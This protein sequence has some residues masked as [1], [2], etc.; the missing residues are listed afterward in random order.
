MGAPSCCG[1]CAGC[2][3]CSPPKKMHA[4]LVGM[5]ND[6]CTSCDSL[7]DED[8]VIVSSLMTSSCAWL[9]TG[10]PVG[11]DCSRLTEAAWSVGN[12]RITFTIQLDYCL[13]LM[14]WHDFPAPPDCWGS[15]EAPLVLEFQQAYWCGNPTKRLCAKSASLV[16]VWGTDQ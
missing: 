9:W 5:S 8:A 1:D 2:Q 16:K 14:F 3:D 6:T 4:K 13:Q 12:C 15:E 11:T 7:N 10:P